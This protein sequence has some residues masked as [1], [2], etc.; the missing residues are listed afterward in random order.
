MKH[1]FHSN[2]FLRF[3][4]LLI[5]TVLFLSCS[6]KETVLIE[7]SFQFPNQ[8]WSFDYQEVALDFEIKK[9]GEPCKVVLEIEQS[10]LTDAEALPLTITITAP[11]GA[12]TTR[13]TSVTMNGK[14]K[15]GKIIS[16]VV[17][18]QEKYFNVPGKYTIEIYRKYDKFDLYGINSV[19][20]KIVKLPK[21]TE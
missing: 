5:T 12:E 13:R 20:A 16:S 3:S 15:A 11:D 10:A 1:F 8:N 9:P 6:N 2:T 19:T 4:I 7:K 14:E 17:A 18:Y 21:G